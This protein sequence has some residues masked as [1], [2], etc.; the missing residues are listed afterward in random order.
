M[1]NS[2]LN[3]EIPSGIGRENSIA[4]MFSEK[5]SH[6]L[7]RD[8]FMGMIFMHINKKSQKILKNLINDIIH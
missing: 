6:V 2:Y 7:A 5:V 4:A 1:E 3:V 8:C